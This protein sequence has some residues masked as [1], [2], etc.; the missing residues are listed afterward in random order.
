VSVYI[1]LDNEV[2]DADAYGAYL[3]AVPAFVEKYGGE[4]LARGG[5]FEVLVGDWKPNRI[6]MFRF[7]DRAAFQNMLADP[8]YQPLMAIREAAT[9]TRNLL[10]VDGV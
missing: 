10:V 8:D 7:P 2:H 3:E 9:T 4:Y 5:A 6:V 1:V